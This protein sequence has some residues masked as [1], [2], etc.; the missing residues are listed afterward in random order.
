MRTLHLSLA[1]ALLG[2]S[3]LSHAALT[4]YSQD[5][6]GLDMAS[7][8]ALS[9]DGW[10][11]FRNI[12]DSNGDFLF[13]NGPFPAPNGLLGPNGEA[14][15]SNIVTGQAGPAQGIQ[16]LAFYN[17]YNDAAHLAGSLGDVIES[18]FFQQQTI[19]AGDGGTWT[20]RWDAKPDT[21]AAAG[22]ALAFF[23]VLDPSDG[24]SLTTFP[25]LDMSGIPGGW[26]TYSLDIMIPTDDSWA[27][28]L[29]QFGFLNTASAFSPSGVH[30][31]NLNFIP[32]PSAALL[33]GFGGLPL[34]RRRR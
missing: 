7:P 14:T 10:L 23:K 4:A 13:G 30:Y 1:L 17:D 5:F 2:S 26:D 6:E 24:F 28:R 27:G 15:Y 29:L 12:Y 31:D 18:N 9:D 16:S 20:F 19:G 22:D 21:P 34:F 33:L 3:S 25:T 8:S 32:E 11:V